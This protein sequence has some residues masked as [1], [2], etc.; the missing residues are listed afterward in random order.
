MTTVGARHR[1]LK[2]PAFTCSDKVMRSLW[3]L[4][5]PKLATPRLLFR[6]GWEE[7]NRF[8]TGFLP[9]P[10]CAVANH[11]DE[12]AEV[13]SI[14]LDIAAQY[15]ALAG[16]PDPPAPY[17]RPY[18][19]AQWAHRLNLST[20]HPL[21]D[22]EGAPSCADHLKASQLKLHNTTLAEGE[23]YLGVASSSAGPCASR[24]SRS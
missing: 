24:P 6:L 3:R 15:A 7:W 2:L 8:L 9:T 22:V 1:Q 17:H 20:P 12:A 13:R 14:M 18:P 19:A 4:Q 5:A 23:V 11:A 21:P 16:D 10:Q